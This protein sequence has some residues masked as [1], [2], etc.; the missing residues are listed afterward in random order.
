[1]IS[2]YHQLRADALPYNRTVLMTLLKQHGIQR[3]TIFYSGGGDAGDTD[4]IT[5]TPPQALAI[6]ENATVPLRLPKVETLNGHH[7]YVLTE[8]ERPAL[9]ALREFTLGW[10]EQMHCRWE[11]DDGGAGEVTF[12]VVEDTCTLQHTEYY[13]GSLHHEYTL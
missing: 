5:A 12:D 6:L 9:D 7:T 13:T 4:K 3:L 2:T 10:I 11:N 1:M 8:E